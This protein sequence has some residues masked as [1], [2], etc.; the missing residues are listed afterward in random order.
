MIETIPD[1]TTDLG[2]QEDARLFIQCL[3]KNRT[4]RIDEFKE[5]ITYLMYQSYMQ[6][7]QSGFRVGLKLN[8]QN[9]LI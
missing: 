2:F 8:N 5:Q 3:L 7:L 9:K 6:G 1:L 4:I